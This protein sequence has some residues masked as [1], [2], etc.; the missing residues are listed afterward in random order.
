MCCKVHVLQKG[1]CLFYTNEDIEILSYDGMLPQSP[2][3]ETSSEVLRK[4]CCRLK[5]KIDWLVVQ[6]QEQSIPHVCGKSR[7]YRVWHPEHCTD[8]TAL[9]WVRIWT[10]TQRPEQRQCVWIQWFGNCCDCP[11]PMWGYSSL[12]LVQGTS[13]AGILC[14]HTCTVNTII[15]RGKKLV[16]DTCCI[17][18]WAGNQNE[19][20]SN[21]FLQ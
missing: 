11:S 14:S 19:I 1:P 15:V 18:L 4:S 3:N 20:F 7:A 8:M 13:D 6:R 12:V 21:I 2:S 10:V 16:F 5:R 9:S 17:C